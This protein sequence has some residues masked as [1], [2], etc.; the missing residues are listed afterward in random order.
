MDLLQMVQTKMD[1]HHLKTNEYY[2][3]TKWG[4]NL[5]S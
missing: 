1:L 4:V 3:N 5:I 2:V